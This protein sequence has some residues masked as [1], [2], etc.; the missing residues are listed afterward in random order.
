MLSDEAGSSEE[1]EALLQAKQN[2]EVAVRL[3]AQAEEQLESLRQEVKQL[4]TQLSQAA[5]MPAPVIMEGAIPSLDESDPYAS[6]P[7]L[8]DTPPAVE[9]DTPEPVVL[10]DDEMA[11]PPA[12]APVHEASGSGLIK[13]LLAGLVM[14][15]VVGAGLFWWQAGTDQSDSP[16]LAPASKPVENKPVVAPESDKSEQNEPVS[17]VSTPSKVSS[18]FPLAKGVPDIPR[19]DEAVT[20]KAEVGQALT[21]QEEVQVAPQMEDTRPEASPPVA[22][23]IPEERVE[24]VE[25][26]VE[27]P[28]GQFR[29]RLSDGSSGPAMVRFRADHFLM[30]SSGVSQE[31]DERPQHEVRLGPFAIAAHETTFSEYEMFARATGRRVPDHV[32]WGRAERPVINVSWEDAQAYAQWL[33]AQTGGHYRLPTEAEWEFVAR[34]GTVTRFWWGEDVGENQAN[35]FDCGSVDSGVQTSPVGRFAASPWGVYDMAGNVREWV[36]DCYTPNYSRAPADGSAVLVSGCSERVVRGGAYSSP[37]AQ[38]RSASRDRVDAQSRLDNLGF[39]VV[40]RD[41]K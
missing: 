8:P 25:P 24:P 37:S 15:L 9:A 39:R 41:L 38:L 10:L 14:G 3:R 22:D 17:V 2:V 35:C 13:G 1:S 20:N 4:K 31:F 11:S 40:R 27:Q 7:M 36:E 29:D 12:S 34:S 5:E 30:G 28:A 19:R 23:V 18:T 21:G 26:V 6:N 33:S 32:G 16:A